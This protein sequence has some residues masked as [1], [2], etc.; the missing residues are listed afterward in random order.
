MVVRNA[1][2]TLQ[3][4]RRLKSTGMW[5]CVGQVVPDIWKDHCAFI[6]RVQ[7]SK[8]NHVQSHMGETIM[9]NGW[10]Q[11]VCKPIAGRWHQCHGVGT[12]MGHFWVL[13]DVHAPFSLHGTTF[14]SHTRNY[15]SNDIAAFPRWLAPSSGWFIMWLN[16]AITALTEQWT[17][18]HLRMS[19]IWHKLKFHYCVHISLLLLPIQHASLHYLNNR[20]T[21]SYSKVGN[22]STKFTPLN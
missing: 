22:T 6:R 11:R 13:C 19:C 20:V 5:R 7:P 15:S 4:C 3:H 18:R 1:V 21:T 2:L 9:G 8:N 16:P 17:A 10:P 14:I 12:E